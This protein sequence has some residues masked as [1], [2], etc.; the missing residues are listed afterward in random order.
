MKLKSFKSSYFFVSKNKHNEH[1]KTLCYW[2]TVSI[3]NYTD[4]HKKYNSWKYFPSTFQTF[5]KTDKQTKYN[6]I[7][8]YFSGGFNSPAARYIFHEKERERMRQKMMYFLKASIGW[9]LVE[10]LVHKSI[11]R[12]QFSTRRCTDRRPINP[13][14]LSRVSGCHLSLGPEKGTLPPSVDWQETWPDTDSIE[15]RSVLDQLCCQQGP[16]FFFFYRAAR[17]FPWINLKDI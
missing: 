15:Y 17:F 2:V 12:D 14:L 7:N 11:K 13:T 6:K 5:L 10:T 8:E 16:V 1:S 9:L 3:R 4:R